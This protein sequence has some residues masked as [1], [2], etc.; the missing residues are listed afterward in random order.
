MSVEDLPPY[1]G[2]NPTCP[3]CLNVGAFTEYRAHGTCIHEAGFVFGY[4]D[5]ERLHRECSRCGYRW[6]EAL[7][8]KGSEPDVSPR[9]E[10][11]YRYGNLR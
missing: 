11:T 8:K 7:A 4:D 10:I 6:D 2:D 5:N 3:K 1:S 9:D